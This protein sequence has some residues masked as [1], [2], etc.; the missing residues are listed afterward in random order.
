M[1]QLTDV[2]TEYAK[3][4]L[5]FGCLGALVSISTL[6]CCLF[7]LFYVLLPLM[8]SLARN[9]DGNTAAIV[10]VGGGL[11]ALAVLLGIPLVVALGVIVWRARTLDAI[12]TPLGLS[13]KMYLIYG[14]HYQGQLAGREADAYLFRGPTVELRLQTRVRTRVQFFRRDSIPVGVAGALSKHPLT[15]IPGLEEY[16][17]YALDEVWTRGWLADAQTVQAVQTL[18]TLG[19]EWAIFRSLELWAGEL[20]LRLNRSRRLFFGSIPLESA[21]AW[22]EALQTLARSAETQPAP[23]ATDTFIQGESCQQRERI[24][25]IQTWAIVFIVFVMP[26]CFIAIGIL[27]FLLASLK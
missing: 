21:R 5:L 27:V 26:L 8:D 20:I 4:R 3:R 2:T 22:F 6:C 11:A 25:K 15:P 9:G 10:L 1:R 14:R 7:G 19:A 18:M 13:G 17:V 16:A 23:A 12:F 24:N